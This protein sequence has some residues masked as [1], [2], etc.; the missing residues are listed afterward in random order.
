MKERKKERIGGAQISSITVSECCCVTPLTLLSALTSPLHDPIRAFISPT[1]VS[2]RGSQGESNG[3]RE[4]QPVCFH[5]HS[6]S[7]Q[8]HQAEHT[9][10]LQSGSSSL[11]K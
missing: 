7:E 2:V 8:I 4:I 9:H 6:A 10:T 5:Y 11:D 1:D 3:G